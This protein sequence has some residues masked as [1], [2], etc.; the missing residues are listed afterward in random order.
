MR[1]AGT[2][3]TSIGVFL[4]LLLAGIAASIY[5][6]QSRFD[7]EYFNS[8]LLKEDKAPVRKNSLPVPDSQ[9]PPAFMPESL[10]P[11]GPQE[12]FDSD[13]LSEKIDGKAELYLSSGFVRMS[14]RRFARKAD[15][16]S[17]LELYIYE[18]GKPENAFSVYSLQKRK[19]SRVVGLGVPAYAT[20]DALFFV[21]GPKYFEIISATGGLDDEMVAMAKNLIAAEPQQ[22]TAT[23]KTEASLF[24]EESLDV[25]SI[26]LHMSDVFGFGDLDRVYTASY[27]A[28]DSQVTAFVSKRESP[29]AATQLAEAYGR[30]LIEN[31]ASELGELPNAPGSKIFQVFDTY[32]IVLYRGVFLGGVHEADSRENAEATATRLYGKLDEKEH[33]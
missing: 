13:S 28:G 14:S 19:D 30:F 12:T 26:S 17:W 3:E 16:K 7:P 22:A 32:E 11:M 8:A 4:L 27:G 5:V 24:P 25:A 23:A 1:R 31:G 29:D 2:A 21:N 15:P 9:P 18:M 33:E 10:T 6:V 20:E